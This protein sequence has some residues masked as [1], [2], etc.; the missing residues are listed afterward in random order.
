MSEGQRVE[1]GSPPL[2]TDA[3]TQ[4]SAPPPHADARSHRL[5]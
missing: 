4:S 3:R 1:T 2:H 5:A